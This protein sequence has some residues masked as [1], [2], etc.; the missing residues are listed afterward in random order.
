[1]AFGNISTLY[2]PTAANAG[3]SQWG[4]DVRKL[5]DAADAGSDATTKTNHGTGAAVVRTADPYTTT[6]ADLDQTL[7]GWAVTPS[8]MN[9]VANARRKLAAGNHVGTIRVGHTAATAKNAN[10]AMYVYR[11]GNAAGGRVRTQLGTANSG[12]ISI[13]GLAGEVTFT[14]TVALSEIVLEPDETL[15]YSFEVGAAGTAISGDIITIFTGTQSS[16]VGRIDIPTLTTTHDVSGSL[17]GDG[18]TSRD[19]LA[20][21]EVENLVGDG[22]LTRVLDEATIRSLTGDG[23]LSRSFANAMSRDLFGD[24]TTSE[25]SQVGISRDL[26]GDGAITRDGLGVDITEDLT[27]GGTVEASRTVVAFKTFDLTGDGTIT[28]LHPV[29]AYRTFDLVGE[30]TIGGD[31]TLPLDDLPTGDCPSDWSPNDGLRSIAGDVF[32]HEPPNEGNP[33]EGAVVTLIR[34]SDGYRVGTTTTNAAGHYVF[35][36]DTNDPYTYH[37]EVNWADGGTPQQGLSEGG[38]VPS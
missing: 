13:P 10:I 1:M 29:T 3:S 25:Q 32:F 6:A 20:V 37:V 22:T 26:T 9:S 34:D 36:R 2:L 4:T 5:L 21:G 35:P 8:D 19:G 12:T 23:V 17:V 11:V 28:E 38:C 18:V 24:G 16:V 27:G 15:Q 31:I 14:I 33:V 30:G 7:Y